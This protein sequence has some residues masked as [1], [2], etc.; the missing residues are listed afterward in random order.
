MFEQ[1]ELNIGTLGHVDHGKTTLTYALTHTWTDKHSESIKRSM[2]I[3]LGYADAIIRKCSDDPNAIDYSTSN[4]NN[5]KIVRRISLLDSPGH[6]T[7]MATAIA[8]SNLIDG[9]LF[10]IAANEP[11]PM[12]QTKE[13]LMLINALGLKNTI[14]VQTKVD[15]VGKDAAKKHYQQIKNFIKGSVIENSEI[16][17]V[18][19]SKNI[20]IDYL[21]SKIVEMPI[22]KRDLDSDPLM[23]VARSFDVN[24]PGTPINELIGGVIGG[25][26]I[27]GKFRIGDEIEIRPGIKDNKKDKYTPIITKIL[28]L[29][30]ST[31][32]LEEAKPG[33]LIAIGTPLD[34]AITKAD[35]LVGQVVGLAGK[36][37]EP[38]TQ[39]TL[40]YFDLN[41]SDIPKQGF[42]E[43]EPIIMGIGTGT[44][45][46][47]ITKVKKDVIEV[48]AKRPIIIDKNMKISI[49]RNISQRWRL[50]GYATINS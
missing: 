28:S 5:G 47:Y 42:R 20:N 6:E 33:G 11:C 43:N 41:R 15:I 45:V 32:K 3:K 36:L 30:T 4:C 26:I 17:P 46:G 48:I 22:P 18:V 19:A 8:A 25:S 9:A 39:A 13:H 2:T 44:V 35:S 23:F 40:R 24:R 49:M 31:N 38:I 21:L 10:V 12:P 27:K 16:I 29:S 7:L 1:S 34:P 50:T 14:I 37:P